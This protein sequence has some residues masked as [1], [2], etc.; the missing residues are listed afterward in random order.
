MV[1]GSLYYF[2]FPGRLREK[3]LGRRRHGVQS[4]VG[5]RCGGAVTLS[6]PLFIYSSSSSVTEREQ[7][8]TRLRETKSAVCIYMAVKDAQVEGLN[9]QMEM[10]TMA[11]RSLCLLPVSIMEMPRLFRSHVHNSIFEGYDV[12][13]HIYTYIEIRYVYTYIYAYI[14]VC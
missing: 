9:F 1:G 2:P 11:A 6:V 3:R 5:T 12:Y 10:A 13:L 4:V 8:K 7:K 14:E